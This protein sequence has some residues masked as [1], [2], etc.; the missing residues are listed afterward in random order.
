MSRKKTAGKNDHELICIWWLL[1]YMPARRNKGGKAEHRKVLPLPEK[2]LDN[3]D[4]FSICPQVI[5]AFIP[6]FVMSRG[7]PLKGHNIILFCVW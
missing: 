7:G 3:N 6:P 4:D 2:M 5:L 1:K